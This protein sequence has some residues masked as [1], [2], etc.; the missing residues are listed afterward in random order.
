ML[1]R[2][3][4]F[5][6]LVL[7]AG[8]VAVLAAQNRSLREQVAHFRRE[9][10]VL[11]EGVVVPAFHTTTVQGDPVLIGDPPP[12][13]RQLLMILNASCPYCLTTLPRWK[14]IV[15][16]VRDAGAPADAYVVSLD[17]DSVTAAYLAE[18][19]FNLPAITFPDQRTALVYRAIGVPITVVIG[20][21][22]QV[23]YGRPGLI[24]KRS[25]VDSILTA[26][27]VQP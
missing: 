24:S 12:G 5:A 23:L 10:R 18:H 26:L 4:V 27:G 25:T 3:L 16:R 20:E 6:A 22:G 2:A 8:L 14:E 13:G 1:T 21:G 19:R 9:R 7:A 11:H 15:A 17:P